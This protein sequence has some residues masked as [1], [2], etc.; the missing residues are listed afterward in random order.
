MPSEELVTCDDPVLT[1]LA[2][3]GA[4]RLNTARA[5]V[6]IFDRDY[7]YIIAEA[8]PT[9]P[10]KPNLQHGERD[11]DLWL[12]GTAIPRQHGVCEYALRAIDPTQFEDGDDPR[13]LPIAVVP[14]L[15]ADE[16]F[17]SKPYCKPGSPA[18]F[19]A[20]VPIRT[21]QGINIGVYCVI[22]TEPRDAALWDSHQTELLRSLSGAIVAHLDLRRSTT[23]NRRG[24]L[25]NRGIASFI[26]GKSSIDA[27]SGDPV[28][29]GVDGAVQGAGRPGT[30]QADGIDQLDP[31][32]GGQETGLSPVRGAG[33]GSASIGAIGE[34]QATP[35]F[36]EPEA[37]APSQG[38]GV[39]RHDDRI[40]R[41]ETLRGIFSRAAQII[42][43]SVEVDGFLFL[44]ASV[45]LYGSATGDP[46]STNSPSSSAASGEDPEQ[47]EL[48]A[49]GQGPTC[50]VLGVSATK[51]SPDTNPESTPFALP[52]KVLSK[53]LHR[54]PKGRIFN[55]DDKGDLQHSDSSE[56]QSTLAAR[57]GS[58]GPSGAG[59]VDGEP[60][61]K[62]RTSRLQEGS[63]ILGA[64]PGVRSVAFVPVWHATKERWFAGGFAFTYDDHRILTTEDELSY[65]RAFGMLTMEECFRLETQMADKAKSDVLNSLSHELRSPLH[66]IVL[67][68][69][70]LN[71]TELSVFQGNIVHTIETC[72]RTLLD[73]V[74]H[75]LDFSKINNYM[76]KK[77][78]TAG[79]ERGLRQGRFRTIEAGMQ[80]L[81]SVVRLD[82]LVADVMESVCAGF[83]FQHASLS[84]VG[85]EHSVAYADVRANRRLDMMRAMEELGP[86]QMATGGFRYDFASVSIFIDVEPDVSWVFNTQPG[87]VRRIVMNLFGNSLKYTRRGTI[88][89][90]L[91]LGS[92]AKRKGGKTRVVN[93]TVADT[94]KGIGE[95][96]LRHELFRPFSQE[97]HLAPG[98]GLG[99]SLVKQITSQLKG[100]ISVSSTVGVGTTV[101]VSLPMLPS[102]DDSIAPSEENTEFVQGVSDV[103]G[104]RARL[105]GFSKG[106]FDGPLDAEAAKDER[107]NNYKLV[108][109]ICHDWLRLSVS[110]DS[111][112]QAPDLVICEE[113]AV[114]HFATDSEYP[115]SIPCVVICSNTLIAHQLSMTSEFITNP[116]VFDFVS[117]P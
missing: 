24:N 74:D 96:Y 42:T 116:R 104:Q 108:E 103:K 47:S 76:A 22:D 7:Q 34:G 84:Q 55:F 62:Q 83:N 17:S 65:L 31:K 112:D 73:T 37:V 93:I 115:A 54:Y 70:L 117:Q 60:K 13:T 101:A 111:D 25:M 114:D 105:V 91:R 3:L 1:A 16:R 99:L 2:Q 98:T 85:R 90:A 49:A 21:P 77:K 26:N 106:K 51:P 40:P 92:A 35:Q 18:R 68:I 20:A 75:L 48:H 52:H 94:G 81:Y 41:Q 69:E 88:V 14:D 15:T 10:L 5:L 79:G 107:F 43:E 19:Y 78:R 100:T 53:L 89:V 44:D 39:G 63:A 57:K 109:R 66:G 28:S 110:R 80:T 23:I 95:D 27:W 46:E 32:D 8:T 38:E 56:G 6:S 30:T 102:E 86:N 29:V 45:G 50:R 72:S 61:E 113:G 59:G 4:C 58:R 33:D 97:D 71:D 64:L 11:E 82:V 67:G 9:I 12:C 36:A 87:A